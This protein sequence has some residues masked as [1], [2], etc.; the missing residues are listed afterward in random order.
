MPFCAEVAQDN[1]L[2]LTSTAV[3]QCQG[4]IVLSSADYAK[5]NASWGD[6]TLQN[7]NELLVAIL[8]L[9]AVAWIYRVLIRQINQ[10]EKDVEND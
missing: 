1:L 6:F 8:G 7:A 9:W 2:K 10:S 5:F 3:E 4:V